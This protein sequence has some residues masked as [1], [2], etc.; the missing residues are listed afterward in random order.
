[1]SLNRYI[2]SRFGV[3]SDTGC[4]T[5]ANSTVTN[6]LTRRSHRAFSND[7][8]SED[9]LNTL[10]ATAFSAPSKSDLQQACVIHVQDK[11]RQRRIAEATPSIS[12][13]AD[14]PVFLVW[15][16]DSRRIRRLA[17]WRGH[18]FANDHLDA[19]MNAAVDA[20]ICMQTFIIAAESY[21]LGC[22]P[23]SEVR[24]HVQLLSDELELPRHVFPVAGLCVGWPDARPEISMRLPL[25]TTVKQDRYDDSGLFDEV[26]AYDIRRE[27]LEKTPPEKQRFAETLGVS[28]NYGWSENRSRQ[29]SKPARDDFGDYIRRQGFD[30]S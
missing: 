14:A 13:A 15:C 8:V 12:W 17:E 7:K 24:N 23:V 19:F 2:Q 9:L 20:G 4:S 30:L 11:G 16:G 5:E 18:A 27:A 10:F 25:G 21:G 1:M 3:S 22:C 26:S 29:Y 28:E 6:I